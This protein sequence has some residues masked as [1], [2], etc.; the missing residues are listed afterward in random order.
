MLVLL[1]T[2]LH[3]CVVLREVSKNVE[4][5]SLQLNKWQLCWVIKSLPK[6]KTDLFEFNV[7]A[8]MTSF[9]YSG[10]NLGNSLAY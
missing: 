7:G 8:K 9:F 10:A 3:T 1:F 6:K 4:K 2:L 5:L